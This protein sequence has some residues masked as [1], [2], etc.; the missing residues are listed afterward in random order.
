MSLATKEKSLESVHDDSTAGSVTS[1]EES[2]W[3]IET[4][5]IRNMHGCVSHKDHNKECHFF[6]YP[7]FY[8]KVLS[9]YQLENQM[10]F[11]AQIFIILF[12]NSAVY[13]HQTCIPA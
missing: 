8:V 7:S 12:I 10:Q 2:K 13:Y 4:G 11:V 9:Y 1:N 5:D 3:Q 6:F